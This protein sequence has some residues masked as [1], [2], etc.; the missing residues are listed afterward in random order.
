M[1]A[2][3]NIRLCLYPVIGCPYNPGT[4]DL[5]SH[6]NC[7]SFI[8]QASMWSSNTLCRSA[9]AGSKQQKKVTTDC[10]EDF[11]RFPSVKTFKAGPYDG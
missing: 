9:A 2:L 3:W 8:I 10:H 11:G 7:R 6:T 5:T 1:T 4:R